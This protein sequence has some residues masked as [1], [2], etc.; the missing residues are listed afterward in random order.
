MMDDQGLNVGHV[1]CLHAISSCPLTCMHAC[2]QWIAITG[3][4]SYW[5]LLSKWHDILLVTATSHNNTMLHLAAREGHTEVSLPPRQHLS[6][7]PSLTPSYPA[8]ARFSPGQSL[9]GSP[10]LSCRGQ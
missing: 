3:A 6:Q 10:L 1:S 4:T 7:L 8:A 5:P 2:C 9:R